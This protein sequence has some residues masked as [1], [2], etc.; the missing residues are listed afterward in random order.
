[1]SSNDGVMVQPPYTVHPIE[2]LFS[3]LEYCVTSRA[4]CSDTQCVK[5]ESVRIHPEQG[6]QVRSTTPVRLRHINAERIF[7]ARP[8][9]L[10][11]RY[12][13]VWSGLSTSVDDE[14]L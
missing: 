6:S 12:H 13:R 14:V 8:T 11:L 1:M 7:E 10:P 4:L 9:L 3:S 5:T 2:G